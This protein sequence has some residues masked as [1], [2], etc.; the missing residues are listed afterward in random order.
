MKSTFLY[1][2]SRR[3]RLR[4]RGLNWLRLWLRRG[5]DHSLAGRLLSDLL[6]VELLVTF[7]LHELR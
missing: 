7:L 3:R 2:Y 6:L 5:N 1:F 4:L